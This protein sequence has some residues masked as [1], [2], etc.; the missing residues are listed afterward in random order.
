[1]IDN[2]DIHLL[3]ESLFSCAIEGNQYAIDLLELRKTDYSQF[4][5]RCID[6]G[7]LDNDK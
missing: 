2:N 4:L 5:Q 3:I 1:M 6:D 7:M